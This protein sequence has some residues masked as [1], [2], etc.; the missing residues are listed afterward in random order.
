MRIRPCWSLSTLC[1]L[2]ARPRYRRRFRPLLLCP[3]DCYKIRHVWRQSSVIT[4]LVC[5]HQYRQQDLRT[6]VY[7]SRSTAMVESKV[8]DAHSYQSQWLVSTSLGRRVTAE[9]RYLVLS[10]SLEKGHFIVSLNGEISLLM[11]TPV[12]TIVLNVQNKVISQ[13]ICS[14]FFSLFMG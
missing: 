1:H 9:E 13:F 14:S 5:C 12:T 6:Q 10:A 11:A 7:S 4:S 3:F 8:S 2:H